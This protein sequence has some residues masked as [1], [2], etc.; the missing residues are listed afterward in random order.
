MHLPKIKVIHLLA[1]DIDRIVLSLVSLLNYILGIDVE[2]SSPNEMNPLKYLKVLLLKKDT[3]TK[4]MI[5]NYYTALQEGR[6]FRL[7]LLNNITK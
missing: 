6:I 7:F 1:V 2:S 5:M 3:L 4:C